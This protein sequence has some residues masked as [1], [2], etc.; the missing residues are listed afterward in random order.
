MNRKQEKI[1]KVIGRKEKVRFPFLSSNL[2]DAKIDTGAYTSSI[3]CL[4]IHEAEFRGGK[5][6]FFTVYANKKD[7]QVN[8]FENYYKKK[9]KSS[10]G[11]V[12]DRYIIKTQ[13]EIAG[14]RIKTTLSLAN[15]GSMKYPVLIGRKLLKGKFIVD[16]SKVYAGEVINEKNN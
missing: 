7:K 15:R 12:E 11:E 16:V 14:K 3:H 5:R 2:L 8:S 13:I 1:L 9:I 4:D 10:T 6:L